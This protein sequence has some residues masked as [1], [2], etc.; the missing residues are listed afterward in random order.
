MFCLTSVMLNILMQPC[1]KASY[2][3]CLKQVIL[4]GLINQNYSPI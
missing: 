1:R 4:L 3:F 2:K